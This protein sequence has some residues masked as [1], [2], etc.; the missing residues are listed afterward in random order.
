MPMYS[1]AHQHVPEWYIRSYPIY[2]TV[3][4]VTKCVGVSGRKPIGD[5]FPHHVISN[6]V[7]RLPSPLISNEIAWCCCSWPAVGQ[8]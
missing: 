2:F 8:Q 5:I 3:F 1:S 4:L 7:L 6:H